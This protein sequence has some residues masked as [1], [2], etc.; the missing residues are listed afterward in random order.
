MYIPIKKQKYKY[1][2]FEQLMKEYG[3]VKINKPWVEKIKDFFKPIICDRYINSV[4]LILKICYEKEKYILNVL[5]VE[6][7]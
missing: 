7:E 3:F 4:G 1:S 2:E 5:D 6:F